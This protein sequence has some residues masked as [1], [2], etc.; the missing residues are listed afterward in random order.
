MALPSHTPHPHHNQ[1]ANALARAESTGELFGDY[2]F[3][4]G[5]LSFWAFWGVLGGY[6][7]GEDKPKCKAVLFRVINSSSCKRLKWTMMPS[8]C[9]EV[10]RQHMPF[11]MF[12]LMLSKTLLSRRHVREER[13][14]GSPAWAELRQEEVYR[15]IGVLVCLWYGVLVYPCIHVSVSVGSKKHKNTNK[16]EMT[17]NKTRCSPVFFHLSAY[18]LSGEQNHS[19]RLWFCY[20]NTPIHQYTNDPFH[21]YCKFCITKCRICVFV[22]W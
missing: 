1:Q 6:D 10:Q 19:L 20:H 14:R 8:L 5:N 11:S 18:R 2:A 16:K 12:T 22:Y 7:R 21:S 17:P 15:F 13:Q 3:K 9:Q 4:G